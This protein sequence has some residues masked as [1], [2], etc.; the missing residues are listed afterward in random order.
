M[1]A[2]FRMDAGP[3]AVFMYFYVMLNIN[4][5]LNFRFR[6][7]EVAAYQPDTGEKRLLEN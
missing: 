7:S 5:C 3:G 6:W 4:I 1:E 2:M